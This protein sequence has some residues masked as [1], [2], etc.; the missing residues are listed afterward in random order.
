MNKS[1]RVIKD[2]AMIWFLIAGAVFFSVISFFLVR[3]DWH[4][5]KGRTKI[6]DAVNDYFQENL[7]ERSKEDATKGIK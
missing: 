7:R 4:Y 6:E 5:E 2:V 3:G 1:M